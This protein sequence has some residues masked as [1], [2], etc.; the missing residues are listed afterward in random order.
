MDEV[1]PAMLEATVTAAAKTLHDHVIA[2][3]SAREIA[4]ARTIYTIKNDQWTKQRPWV[5]KAF[6][7]KRPSAILSLNAWHDLVVRKANEIVAWETWTSDSHKAY[8]KRKDSYDVYFDAIMKQFSRF[9]DSYKRLAPSVKIPPFSK[10][11]FTSAYLI[12][13]KREMLAWYERQRP[14]PQLV[15]PNPPDGI[16]HFMN[17]RTEIVVMLK[18]HHAKEHPGLDREIALKACM[19]Q[20][21]LAPTL[22]LI[23]RLYKPWDNTKILAFKDMTEVERSVLALA[24]FVPSAARLLKSGRLVYTP[25]RL[26]Q[27]YGGDQTLWLQ[28]IG[29]SAVLSK[30]RPQQKALDEAYKVMTAVS[31]STKISG[32]VLTD[33]S[34]ATK[35]IVEYLSTNGNFV[36]PASLEV[37]VATLWND[38][39]A[40]NPWFG[41][42]NLDAH[43]LRRI[44]LMGPNLLHIQ[45]QL[46]VELAESRIAK[47]LCDRNGAIALGVDV[48]VDC[49]LEFVPGHAFRAG[50]A[51]KTIANRQITDG[52]IGYWLGDVF[53][54]AAFLEARMSG[55]IGGLGPRELGHSKNA[56]S[57]LNRAEQAQ[58]RAFSNREWI[59]AK[60]VADRAQ[61]E[62]KAKLD[63]YDTD[64]LFSESGSQ[65]ARDIFRLDIL[66][67]VRIN[68]VLARFQ[69]LDKSPQS[70]KILAVVPRSTE[71]VESLVKE[72]GK[73]NEE[74]KTKPKIP[75]Q[76]EPFAVP[77]TAVQLR[78]AAEAV[79]VHAR[80]MV[81]CPG[82]T[83]DLGG[84]GC[85]PATSPADFIKYIQKLYDLA[86]AFSG[87][88][89]A[90]VRVMQYLR[91]IDYNDFKFNQLVEYISPDWI[92]YANATI[93]AN[94]MVDFVA[95]PLYPVN[96]KV[97][98]F[99]ASMN[100]VMHS[101][102]PDVD[103]FNRGCIAG[104][105]G[106]WITFYGE[107]RRDKIM[108]G[109]R[110]CHERLARPGDSS[111]FKLRDL[112]ED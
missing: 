52:V 28:A 90:N 101:D 42:A 97:S 112:I 75:F 64:L 49:A 86:V 6:G 62:F 67:E 27:L 14:S 79:V 43:A 31:G 57:L 34:E 29:Y 99:G 107:W 36:I 81:Y 88:S 4:L 77:V 7:G 11:T 70:T 73:A 60:E 47:L 16:L 24:M 53:Y 3:S 30:H 82:T 23:V 44:L 56:V 84:A 80:R 102:V 71:P 65:I 74:R 35:F 105:G 45:A 41:T 69:L 20:L 55:P 15:L 32:K 100:G 19:L 50:D 66:K 37:S 87:T 25:V 91:H 12:M 10:T 9:Y 54:V 48:P 98:H 104:W 85:N 96:I 89:K 68:G 51:I 40:S 103:S 61:A 63:G 33:A 78:K 22:A 18:T 58:L 5:L 21:S 110:Y 59:E 108:P 83:S 39:Q 38:I 93:K 2:V 106:D 92:A 46:L 8:Q 95:D 13:L 72:V 1:T 76:F 111:T 26:S 17:Q 109:S 94:D